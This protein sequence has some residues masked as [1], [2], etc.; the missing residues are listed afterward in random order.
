MGDLPDALA[1]VETPKAVETEVDEVNSPRMGL[2]DLA[3]SSEMRT[4]P[5]CPQPRM[6]AHRMMVRPT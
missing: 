5:P 2:G 3:V 6:R 4:W 1:S